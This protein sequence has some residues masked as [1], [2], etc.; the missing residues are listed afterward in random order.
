[1][2]SKHLRQA[3]ANPT[4]VPVLGQT[5]NV[6][7]PESPWAGRTGEVV[8]ADPMYFTVR[9]MTPSQVRGIEVRS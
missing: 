5:V 3:V 2:N 1:M 4:A 7:D 8:N 6:T 9:Y